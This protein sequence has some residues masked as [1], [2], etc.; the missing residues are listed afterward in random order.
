MPTNSHAVTVL[1][2]IA[3]GLGLALLGFHVYNA[4]APTTTVASAAKL[5]NV[6]SFSCRLP[7]SGPGQAGF[8]VFPSRNQVTDST[9]HP[10]GGVAFTKGKGWINAPARLMSP[11]ATMVAVA[12]PRNGQVMISD[13]NGR[14]MK[15]FSAA[16]NQV[17]GWTSAGIVAWST[18]L[19][20][21]RVI[22]PKDGTYRAFAAHHLAFLAA[23]SSGIWSLTGGLSRMDPAT[24]QVTLWYTFSK[25]SAGGSGGTLLGFD[26]NGS[27]VVWDAP[28]YADGAWTVVVLAGPGIA[29]VLA[30]SSTNSLFVPEHALGD[31]HGIWFTSL[32]GSVWLSTAGGLT[33]IGGTNAYVIAGPCT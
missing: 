9:V 3:A 19:D 7:V 5:D 18:S 17:I 31:V 1:S 20:Q 25:G 4:P 21:I 6:P 12:D 32:A 29:H 30:T 8:L 28:D 33:Q 22:N 15:Q 14:Q 13:L 2:A 10:I 16:V 26:V 11:D 24:G 23:N 27:P